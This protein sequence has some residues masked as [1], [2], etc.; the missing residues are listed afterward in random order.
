MDIADPEDC[1]GFL[2]RVGEVENFICDSSVIDMLQKGRNVI[3]RHFPENEPISVECREVV[4][5]F[6][7]GMAR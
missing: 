3:H 5:N 7:A 6:L 4:H 2:I 1:L